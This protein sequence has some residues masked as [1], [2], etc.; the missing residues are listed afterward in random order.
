M[1]RLVQGVD[2]IGQMAVAVT[3]QMHVQGQPLTRSDT[4]AVFIRNQDERMRRGR[5]LG[6]LAHAGIGRGLKDIGVDAGTVQQT[7]RADRLVGDADQA[8]Q[9][10]AEGP[11]PGR[12]GIG[13]QPE[14]NRSAEG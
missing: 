10:M 4:P 5:V 3:E 1:T 12:T 13:R 11:T 14:I 7:G 6:E 8:F 2:D 9:R